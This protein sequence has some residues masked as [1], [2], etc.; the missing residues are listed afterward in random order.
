M[1]VGRTRVKRN[2]WV[3]KDGERGNKTGSQRHA[4]SRGAQKTEVLEV[5]NHQTSYLLVPENAEIMQIQSLSPR[6][7]DR[8]QEKW[9]G[10][11]E[12]RPYWCSGC[13]KGR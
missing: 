8:A 12:H 11:N 3:K 5:E 4:T 10:Q 9:K 13:A 7:M 2:K 1:G 6:D